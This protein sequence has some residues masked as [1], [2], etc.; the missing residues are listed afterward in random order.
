MKTFIAVS[1]LLSLV[2]TAESHAAPPSPISTGTASG[3]SPANGV[4]EIGTDG[5]AVSMTSIKPARAAEEIRFMVPGAKWE[6]KVTPGLGQCPIVT[7]G[8]ASAEILIAANPTRAAQVAAK[9]LQHYVEKITGA[10]LALV[11]DAQPPSGN[12]KIL[13]GE[14]TWTRALGL[15]DKDFAPQEYLIRNYGNLLVLMGSDEQEFGVIDYEGNGLWPEFT[16]RE[17]SKEAFKKIGS[18]YAVHEFL[19]R[20]CGVRWYFPGDLGEVCPTQT[21]LAASNLDL[22]LQPWS[23]YRWIYPPGNMA[24]FF[25][26]VGSDKPQ[27]NLQE[28]SGWRETNLWLARMK[29]LGT[30]LYSSNH[31]LGSREWKKR[32]KDDPATWEAIRA[33]NPVDDG[34][35]AVHG[36]QLCLS[37][38]KLVD[39]LVQDAKDYAAGKP[40]NFNTH[41]KGDC[42][43][44]FP[45]DLTAWCQCELCKEKLQP[46][47]KGFDSGHTGVASELVWSLVNKVA[48][49]LQKEAPSLRVTCN[50]YWD[51]MLPPSFDLEPNVAVMISRLLP[52]ELSKPGL[53]EFYHQMLTE[54]SKRS[55][56]GFY[57]WEYFDQVQGYNPGGIDVRFPGIFL[58]VLE[59]DTRF[60]RSLG[61]KGTFNE[62]LI[63]P[64][65]I[66]N[67][68]QD[69]LNFYVWSRLMAQD[70]HEDLKAADLL[71][72]YCKVFYG[73]AAAPMKKFF[74]LA[75]ER[76][77]NPE[78][79]KLRPDQASVDWEGICPPVELERF[80]GFLNE[81]DALAPDGIYATRVSLIREAVFNR[82]EKN[83]RNVNDLG[84]FLR[85]IQAKKVVELPVDG[86]DAE[87]AARA[88]RIGDFRTLDGKPAVV[89]T[90]ARMHRDRDNLYVTVICTE[91]EMDKVKGGVKAD[92]SRT[93]N[94]WGD[95][96][97]ELFIDP[98]AASNAELNESTYLQ[99]A[100]NP[101]GALF[102]KMQ[103]NGGD[104]PGIKAT[105]ETGK[106]NWTAKFVVPLAL[107]GR[108]VPVAGD[109]W[110]LNI[111]RTRRAGGQPENTCWSPTGSR[112]GETKMFGKIMFK[113]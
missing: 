65:G 49:R 1:A 111:G 22:K 50:A 53:K 4:G 51:Y 100:V 102:V 64:V 12:P 98:A 48:K 85:K 101:N 24:D 45:A 41:A 31:T 47:A 38:D 86:T 17:K 15:S 26:F 71:E 87:M 6:M 7:S 83:C 28:T 43:P 96:T 73:P 62:L 69:H 3:V 56:S 88:A 32:F 8:K 68:I 103:P 42:F 30:K 92:A 61:L 20:K 54:W 78:F 107:L 104:V 55:K 10:K 5:K 63:S 36:G 19:Q 74:E 72:D 99:V 37:S 13:V 82:M 112:F 81:A 33:K 60:L 97:V 113:P 35:T 110:G 80:R 16:T 27:R 40:N 9:E 57:L 2:L 66:P 90:A 52:F 39:I 14:S 93:A 79:R 91:P 58:N 29:I 34:R 23:E 25:Y 94:I 46:E 109:V 108:P 44:V 70:A 11:T 77:T 21:S 105:V 67:F 59:D 89:A 95:D 75:Q 18:L 76:Y 106:D 84:I